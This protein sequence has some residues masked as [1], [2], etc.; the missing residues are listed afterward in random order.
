M[1]QQHLIVDP[2]FRQR[3]HALRI[4]RGL[5]FRDLGKL[6]HYSH[7]QVWEIENGT[8]Q[9]TLESAAALDSALDAGGSLAALVVLG[10]RG[11][12]VPLA[13]LPSFDAAPLPV[14]DFG[15]GSALV[16]AETAA[17]LAAISLHY[18][19]SYQSVPASKLL[20]AARAH[21]DLVTAL[22]PAG[23]DAADRKTLLRT[24]GEMATLIAVL[25]SL[26][27]RQPADASRYLNLAWR[28]ARDAEDPEL[29]AVVLG[30]RSFA[31]SYGTGDHKQG[32]EYADLAREVAIDG[33]SAETRAWVAAVASERAASIGDLAGSQ[34]RLE[35]SRNALA[36]ADT[37]AGSWRGVGGFNAGKLRAY[38]GGNMVRLRRFDAAM[39]ILDA[40][41]VAL[42]STM[43]RHR[44]TAFVDRAEAH[45]GAGDLDAACTD[46][47][48]ALALVIRVQHVGD[49]DRITAVADAVAGTG[50]RTARTLR[51]DVQLAR[52]DHN[53]PIRWESQT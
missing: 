53:Q 18:R 15:F 17:G 22:H 1:A 51:R 45:L 21:L 31:A 4:Q 34:R 29:Q 24:V 16:S 28:A 47:T 6:A 25:L 2:E 9:P 49:L 3:V 23:S 36:S 50:G 32:L 33:A 39:P 10:E 7:T 8:K 35:E 12:V 38:E 48:D 44:G 5:T 43:H 40:A 26:D 11:G 20:P 30:V 27:I 46:A 42:D 19:R 14:S 41:L 13:A 52:A 37:G